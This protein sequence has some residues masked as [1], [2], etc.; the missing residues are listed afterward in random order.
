M[1]AAL[2]GNSPVYTSDIVQSQRLASH[3]PGLR[4][5]DSNYYV[6]PRLNTKFGERSFLEN[7]RSRTLDH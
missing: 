5:A 2:N 6:K 3:R 4:S 1:Y 7:D